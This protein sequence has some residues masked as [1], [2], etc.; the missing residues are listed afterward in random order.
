MNVNENTGSV[1]E[2]PE[3]PPALQDAGLGSGPPT[4][5]PVTIAGETAI[6]ESEK[7]KD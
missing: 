7:S 2:L 1:P 3:Q 5:Q 6:E 4:E